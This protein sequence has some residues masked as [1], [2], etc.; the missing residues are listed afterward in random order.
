MGSEFV[1]E[2]A[3]RLSEIRSSLPAGVQLLAVSKT[4]PVELIQEAYDAGQRLFGE[5]KVQEMT[6]K[7]ALLPK[8]IEWHFIGHVQRNKIRQM[9]PY[10][11]VIQGIDSFQALAETD[12]QAKAAGRTVTCLLQIHIAAEDTKFGFTAEECLEM[13]RQGEWRKLDN[14]IIGGVMGMATNTD[15]R[16][17]VLAEFRRLKEV[18]DSAKSGFFADDANFR[19]ISAGMSDDRDLAIQAGSNMVRIGTDIFGHRNYAAQKQ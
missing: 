9:V 14:V 4:H 16:E 10:I 5:N 15:N 7:Q 18:F 8:D 1:T 2:T 17:Q 6:M 13:L 11:S 3:K 19:T 12:R